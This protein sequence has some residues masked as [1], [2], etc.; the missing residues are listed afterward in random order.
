MELPRRGQCR[1]GGIR[2]FQ[3]CTEDAQGRV[4]QELVDETAVLPDGFDDD[5]EELV[6]QVDDFAWRM[7]GGQLGRAH[8]I[9]EQHRDVAFLAAQFGTALQCPSRDVLADVAAEQVAHALAFTEFA[10]HVVEA[11][12][13]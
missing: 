5:V 11:G 10:D 7:G 12:L 4:A 2:V 13:Q 6:E 3:R 1:T 9:D 8:Q